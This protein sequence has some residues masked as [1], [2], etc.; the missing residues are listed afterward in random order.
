[1]K[2]QMAY[3]IT[4]IPTREAQQKEQEYENRRGQNASSEAR[5]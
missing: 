4:K 1:M 3:T 2:K 5:T